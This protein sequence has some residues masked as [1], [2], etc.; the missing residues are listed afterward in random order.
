MKTNNHFAALLVAMVEKKELSNS[1][2]VKGFI[3]QNEPSETEWS[4]KD[5]ITDE[6]VVFATNFTKR[7]YKAPDRFKAY[8]QKFLA[9]KPAE[10]YNRDAEVATQKATT[11]FTGEY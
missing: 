10:A 7:A 8:M 11:R 2:L 6:M 1:E 4:I 9:Q 3:A 5:G